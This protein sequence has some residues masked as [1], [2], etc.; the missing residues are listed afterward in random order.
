MT[1]VSSATH[2]TSTTSTS[3]SSSNSLDSSDFLSLLCTELENQDPLD[4]L[5]SSEEITQLAQYSQLESMLNMEDTMSTL[6]TTVTDALSS[7]T[8]TTSYSTGVSLLNQDVTTKVS[9]VDYSGDAGDEV[10]IDINMGSNEST[11]V[12]LLNSSGDVV[13]TFTA[14]ADDNGVA[15][16]TWNGISELD[17]AY[18]DEGTYT[19]NIPDASSDSSL[20]AYTTGTVTAV[21]KDADDGSTILTVNGED[22]S[23]DDVMGVTSN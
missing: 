2:S 12:E 15:E 10:T 22:V 7:I 3:S 21:K 11:T 23:L 18:A 9:S 19:I 13:K 17:G 4:P 1:T 6:S 16:L 5:S 14:T 20:Y 8:N